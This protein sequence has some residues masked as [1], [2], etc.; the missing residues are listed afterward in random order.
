MAAARDCLA[1]LREALA[2]L[3]GRPVLA[4]ILIL[5]VLLTATNILVLQNAPPLGTRTLPPLFIAA[6][7]ARVGGLLVLT[8]AVI[9]ILAG[10]TRSPWRPD[11]AFWLAC[12]LMAA[13]FALSAGIGLLTSAPTDPLGSALSGALSGLIIAPFSPWLVALAA[14]RPLAWSPLPWLRRFGAWLGQLIVWT[15]LLVTPLAYVH[16]AIDIAAVE[17]RLDPFWPVMLFDGPLSA[18]I[19]LLGLALNVAAY[20]R[21]ARG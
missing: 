3:T 6:A 18:V 1:F 9:R 20:R 17:G 19:A 14:E 16:I 4:P 15:T 10:S 12:L 5:I 7:I 8:V 13:L 21:V 11:G 2:P